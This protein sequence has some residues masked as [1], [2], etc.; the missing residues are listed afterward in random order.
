M[1]KSRKNTSF[2]GP[3]CTLTFSAAIIDCTPPDSQMR[4]GKHQTG[5]LCVF[6]IGRWSAGQ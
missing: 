3:M 2:P 5:A 1:G 6:S 4:A